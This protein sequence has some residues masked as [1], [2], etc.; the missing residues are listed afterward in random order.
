M[1]RSAKIVG[2][3]AALTAC[4]GASAGCTSLGQ[5][6]GDVKSEQLLAKDCWC[7]SY[8]MK[9]DFFAAVPYRDTLQLRVQRGA[10]LQEISD[11]LA[12]LVDKVTTI[13]ESWRGKRLNVSLPSAIELISKDSGMLP[14]G[15]CGPD[16]MVAA[17]GEPT[18]DPGVVAAAPPAD[19]GESV[20]HMALYLQQSCHNQ[21]V[22]LYAVSGGIVFNSLFSGDPNEKTGVDKY[23]DAVF[24]VM[25]GDPQDAPPGT[26]PKDIPPEKLTHLQGC[27]RFYFER[28]Q[29]GQPFP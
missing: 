2:M 14:S 1:S 3:A 21:N 18:C 20:V 27:F 28:G 29:P 22:V 4:L 15:G 7:S 5:G 23:T 13:R 10:D 26:D 12:V 19:E 8:D 6:E 16:E 17:A 25:V 11:G 24:D 9:P